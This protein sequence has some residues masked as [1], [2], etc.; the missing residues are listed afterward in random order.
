MELKV[1]SKT[2]KP[3]QD[4]RPETC[5]PDVFQE[6]LDSLDEVVLLFCSSHRTAVMYDD[7]SDRTLPIISHYKLHEPGS[8]K[9]HI[10]HYD[11]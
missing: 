7:T 4:I 10:I 9:H 2:R 11:Y 5:G 6:D 8:K 3:D 1:C